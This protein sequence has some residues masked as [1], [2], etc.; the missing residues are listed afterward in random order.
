MVLNNIKELI[1]G[2]HTVLLLNTA[3]SFNK[4]FM[5]VSKLA[6]TGFFT[7]PKDLGIMVSNLAQQI[8]VYFYTMTLLYTFILMI[9]AFLLKIQQQLIIGKLN[10][11]AQNTRPDIS[12]AVHQ[13]AKFCNNPHYSHGIVVKRIG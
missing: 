10:F 6:E 13:C 2:Q 7:F 5:D 4:I 9:A 11:L 3:L 1:F 12:F 8:H